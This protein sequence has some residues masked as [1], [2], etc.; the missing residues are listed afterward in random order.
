MMKINLGCGLDVRA[1]WVNADKGFGLPDGVMPV[2][3]NEPRWKFDDDSAEAIDAIDV[4]E[5]LQS[6]VVFMDECWRVLKPGGVL[7]I[8]VPRFDHPN[9]W[10]D[11]THVRAFT[12]DTFDYFD[13]DSEWGKR[14]PMYSPRKWR[15]LQR[16]DAVTIAVMLTP[17]KYNNGFENEAD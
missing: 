6:V 15:V 11:P 7:T 4:V 16:Q 14:Y 2:D 10:L 13:P 1:G 12:A 9:L 17:R 5:H 3:L 8:Q